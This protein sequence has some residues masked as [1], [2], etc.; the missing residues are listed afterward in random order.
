[1]QVRV[2]ELMA[3]GWPV[4]QVMGMQNLRLNKLF[5]VLLGRWGG[6]VT[7]NSVSGTEPP[8]ILGQHLD[9]IYLCLTLSHFFPC[10]FQPHIRAHALTPARAHAH[11]HP[12]AFVCQIEDSEESDGEEG[13]FCPAQQSFRRRT[14]QKAGNGCC[15]W[16]KKYF[17][18][19]PSCEGSI[20]QQGRLFIHIYRLDNYSRVVFPVTFFFFNVLY[21]LVCLNL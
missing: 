2:L 18:V 8:E 20:W 12:E 1:M 11:Q 3:H 21:W 15:E 9:L 14:I 10:L 17:C 6:R 5:D 19:V 16:C 13:P 7:K 4:H